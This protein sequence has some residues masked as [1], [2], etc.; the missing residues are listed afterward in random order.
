MQIYFRLTLL[1]SFLI[2]SGS[3][4][5]RQRDK[6]L[7]FTVIAH[8]PASSE[9]YLGS[10]SM[11]RLGNGELLAAHDTFG[12]N[13]PKNS[14][15]EPNRT[16][17]YRSADD[18]ETW[19]KLCDI[20]DAYWSS[21]FELKGAVYLLGTACKNGHIV[22]RRSTDFGNTWT[23]PGDSSNGLLFIGGPKN[24]PPNYHCAPVPVVIHNGR[25]WRAFEDNAPTESKAELVGFAKDFKSLVISADVNSDLLKASSWTMSDKLPY[26]QST[27]R[28]DFGDG[29]GWLEGNIVITPEHEIVNIL[30]VDSKPAVDKAAMIRVSAD[31]K[32]LTFDPNTGFIDFPGGMSKFTI[33]YDAASQ[34][35]WTISNNNT[36][37]A[38][39]AQ[40]NV[41]SLFSSEDLRSWKFERLL[42]RDQ[43]DEPNLREDSKVGFQ[44]VDWF[45][46]GDDILFICRTAYNGAHNFH[47]ANYISFH[48]IKQATH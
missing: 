38:N 23:A 45:I 20:D 34:K 46:E 28:E 35:Y 13:A 14:H 32:R 21:L 16:S 12:P 26:D 4:C 36:N 15:G 10:P 40:R 19:Q 39:P 5:D 31:G 44:Y 33:R 11:I 30:R 2:F 27:D 18:G 48:R 7:E 42:L 6:P 37:P 25:V 47:D 3:S 9:I 22:I 41:L 24:T 43:Q 1:V 17:I 8:S 29:A